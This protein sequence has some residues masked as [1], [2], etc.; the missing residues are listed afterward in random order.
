MGTGCVGKVEYTPKGDPRC[1]LGHE[2]SRI[3]TIKLFSIGREW[4]VEDYFFC[5][6]CRE[7]LKGGKESEQ[8]S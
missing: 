8:S 6:Q 3:T 1:P 4:E 7:I 5:P 2:V